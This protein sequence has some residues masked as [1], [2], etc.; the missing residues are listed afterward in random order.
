[1]QVKFFVG[2][3]AAD[4]REQGDTVGVLNRKVNR[5]LGVQ[6]LGSPKPPWVKCCLMSYYTDKEHPQESRRFRIFSTRLPG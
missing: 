4:L 5:L 3:P 2:Y 6:D 1:M